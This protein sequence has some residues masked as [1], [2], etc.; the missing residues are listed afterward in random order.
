MYLRYM[1]ITVIGM[2]LLTIGAGAIF[3]PGY[4]NE[5]GVLVNWLLML[6]GAGILGWVAAEAGSYRHKYEKNKRAS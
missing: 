4:E 3:N 2:L 6:I 5:H 1:F